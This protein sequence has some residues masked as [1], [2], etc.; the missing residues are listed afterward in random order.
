MLTLAGTSS[1]HSRTQRRA[2]LLRS[3]LGAL[4]L[5]RSRR[6][7]GELD[8]RLL[9]DIGL[10]E[11]DARIEARRSVWDVPAAWRR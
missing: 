4:V 8:P 11:A 2:P 9:D 1:A 7:L 10:T 3:L 6:S 5:R